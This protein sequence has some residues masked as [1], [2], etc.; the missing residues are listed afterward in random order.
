MTGDHPRH[1]AKTLVRLK[2]VQLAYSV[3]E[4]KQESIAHFI[5]TGMEGGVNLLISPM[6]TCPVHALTREGAEDIPLVHHHFLVLSD[7][8]HKLNHQLQAAPNRKLFRG[9]EQSP[10][11]I[12]RRAVVA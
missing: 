4:G 8:Y 11:A 9:Q 7:G 2:I 12:F 1:Q 10:N 3:D 5:Y 6:L